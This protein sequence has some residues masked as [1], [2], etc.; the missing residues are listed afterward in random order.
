MG[1][2]VRIGIVLSVIWALVGG[3]LGN[4]AAINDA[5]KLTSAQVDSCVAANKARMRSNADRSEPYDQIWKPC[6]DQFEK[7]YLQNVE[8]HWWAAAFVGLAPI[9]VAWLIV[10]MIVGTYRWVRRGFVKV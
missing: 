4:S 10:Y 7:N 9:P 5:S 6:W 3:F 8:G 2:W 1:G